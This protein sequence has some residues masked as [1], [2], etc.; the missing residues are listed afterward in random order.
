MQCCSLNYSSW[1]RSLIWKEQLANSD[2]DPGKVAA[3][4]HFKN[5]A[6]NEILTNYFDEILFTVKSLIFCKIPNTFC[7]FF[8]GTGTIYDIFLQKLQYCTNKKLIVYAF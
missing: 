1:V 3:K 2:P 7:D 5:V 6:K 8:K 4:Q